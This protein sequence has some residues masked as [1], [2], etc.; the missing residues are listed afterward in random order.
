MNAADPTVNMSIEPRSDQLNAEDLLTGPRT[1]TIEKVASGSAEQPVNVHLAEFPGRPFR[2]SKTV[3]RIM[4]AAWGVDAANYA[5]H[6]M[7]LYRDPAVRFGGQ[8]VGGIR[9]SHMSHIGK[10]I[11][12]AL[13]V[14]RGRRSPYVVDPLP[15]VPPP[16]EQSVELI[17]GDQLKRLWPLLSNAGLTEPDEALAKLSEVLE[18]DVQST[19]D[20][21]ADE[22]DRIFAEF[23]TEQP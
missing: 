20:I 5:G 9:V 16:T 2:P 7:T 1:V 19:K 11:T 21:H 17:T 22:V 13:T 10:R 23:E 14:T 8:D 12:L 4:V 18:R 3:R 6:R 15:D